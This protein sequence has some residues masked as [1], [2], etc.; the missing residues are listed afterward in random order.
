MLIRSILLFI[1]SAPLCAAK[2]PQALM[3]ADKPVDSLCFFNLEDKQD[4]ITLTHC[5][6]AKDK[7]LVTGHNAGLLKKGFTGF[8]WKATD[9]SYPSQ[10]YSYY[11][12]FDAGNQQYW[13]YS[14]NNGGGSGDFT[15]VD[16]VARVSPEQL[17]I[18]GITGGD[19]CNGGV[20][21]V[22]VSGHRLTYSVNLTAADFPSLVADDPYQV[23]AYD[24]LSAC[25]VCCSGKAF[26]SVDAGLKP[27][28]QYVDFGS[29][30]TDPEQMPQQGSLQPCF[31][32]LLATYLNK[33]TRRLDE[34]QLRRFVSEFNQQCAKPARGG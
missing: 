6:A 13:I 11:Q 8:D 9:A 17:S 3:F 26:Y 23:Q 14:A 27:R 34:S 15:A 2:L 4:R 24:E 21:D 20:Q 16:L 33:G 10:G 1:L 31:N 25:A 30:T 12:W 29:S 7:V 18:Q 32:R 5:G 28:L 19:R 22:S